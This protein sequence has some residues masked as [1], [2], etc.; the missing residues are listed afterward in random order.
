VSVEAVSVA[1]FDLT[2]FYTNRNGES[3]P[4]LDREKSD[5][6]GPGDITPPKFQ[7]TSRELS[8]GG[9]LGYIYLSQ[10]RVFFKEFH[11]MWTNYSLNP[12]L[13]WA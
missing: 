13:I 4:S 10:Y 1:S 6:K 5:V 12:K 9:V 7:I 2:L 8:F 3:D 11:H